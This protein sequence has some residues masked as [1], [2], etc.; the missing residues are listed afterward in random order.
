MEV[1]DLLAVAMV[2]FSIV[3]W[4]VIFIGMVVSRLTGKCSNFCFDT[5][6]KWRFFCNRFESIAYSIDYSRQK[7]EEAEKKVNQK[8]LAK[9]MN[10]D[11]GSE[12]SSEDKSL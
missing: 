6:C 3:G 12:E 9:L 5:K 4:I 2:L 8:K 7:L 10:I 1:L 11:G